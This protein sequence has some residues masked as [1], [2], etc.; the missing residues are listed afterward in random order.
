MADTLP[1]QD[2]A[3]LARYM[4]GRAL[5]HGRRRA[6]EVREV[7]LTV[8][9]AGL[10]PLMSAA[11]AQRQDWAADQGAALGEAGMAEPDLGALV[12]AIAARKAATA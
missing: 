1:G 5:Q 6:E 4:M 12:D 3:R 9:D 8:R 7:A 10:D 2:P 11:I